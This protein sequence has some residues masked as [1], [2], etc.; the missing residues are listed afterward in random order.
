MGNLKE[1]NTDWDSAVNIPGGSNLRVLRTYPND[2]RSKLAAWKQ[3]RETGRHS[4]QVGPMISESWERCYSAGVGQKKNPRSAAVDMGKY[5][6]GKEHF[7]SLAGSVIETMYPVI[8][9]SGFN[10]LLCDSKGIILRIYAGGGSGGFYQNVLSPGMSMA[11]AEI[12]TN[13][14]GL[15]LLLGKPVQVS[16]PEHYNPCLHDSTCAAGLIYG[17]GKDVVGIVGICGPYR[18][19]H[20]HTLGMAISLSRAVSKEMVICE[21]SKYLVI[22]EEYLN[23]ISQTGEGLIAFDENGKMVKVNLRAADMLGFTAPDEAAGQT[24]DNTFRGVNFNGLIKEARRCPAK[25]VRLKA[26][27][28]QGTVDYRAQLRLI[29]ESDKP[30]GCVCRIRPCEKREEQSRSVDTR[31]TFADMV[32]HNVDFECSVNLARK[33]AKSDSRILLLGESGTGKEIF[34]QSIHNLSSRREGPFVAINCGAIPKELLESELFGYEEGAFT[35]ARRGGQKGKFELAQGGTLFLDEIGELPY[36]MQAKLLRVLE[37]KK[38]RRVGGTRVIDLNCRVISSTNR[39]LRDEI[40]VRG[41]RDDLYFRLGVITICIPPLRERSDDLPHLVNHIMS[42]KSNQLNS[43]MAK[44]APE[45]WKIFKCYHWPGNIR[46]LENIIERCLLLSEGDCIEVE[47][48]PDEFREPAHHA[49]VF[50]KEQCDSRLLSLTEVEKKAIAATLHR[51]QGGI[52]EAA[53][54]LGIG[55]NTLYRKIEKYHIKVG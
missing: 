13:S 48:L 12:G 15:A 25:R 29:G 20:E 46:E 28:G 30:L 23:E 22:L 14:M 2:Y 18:L 37:E 45:V 38:M 5:L 4:D 43:S 10:V 6:K 54:I 53:R 52:A 17:A 16:G 11:E 44:I 36:G 27:V 26:H 9:S 32:G 31:Y 55:R 8:S 21:T 33:A 1:S 19:A 34:A 42:Q 47:H 51:T 39:N 3:F 49:P 50:A 41:F 40:R 35:G 24:F 7:I